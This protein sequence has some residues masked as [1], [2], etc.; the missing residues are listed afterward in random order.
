[1]TVGFAAFEAAQR[2]GF[3]RYRSGPA[4]GS[5]MEVFPHASAVVLA[6]C[7]PPR[8]ASKRD[9]RRAALR[10]RGVDVAPLRSIDQ[11]DATLAALTGLLAARGQCFAPGDPKEGIIVLPAR[12]LP[13]PPFRRCAARAGEEPT[14]P[15]L[16]GFALCSCG[17]PGCTALTSSEFAPGHDAK[18]KSMLWLRARTGDE[19]VEELRRRGWELPP[20]MR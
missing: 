8:D 4:R 3:P 5:A 18:R 7:L 14:E 16:P 11:L 19:A 10:T 9:F 1:M 20:E 17:D 15:T 2:C 12:S 13:P 6:G